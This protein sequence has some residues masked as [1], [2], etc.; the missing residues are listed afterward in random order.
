MITIG[1]SKQPKH[2]SVFPILTL[3][4]PALTVSLQLKTELSN[5]INGMLV[6]YTGQNKTTDQT[7]DYIQK[8]V[9]GVHKAALAAFKR[10]RC[11]RRYS[12]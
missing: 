9:S 3:F 6:N 8:T 10:F 12:A 2:C 5:I 1:T 7:W 4:P 11:M